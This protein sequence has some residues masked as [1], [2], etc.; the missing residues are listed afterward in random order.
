[1]GEQQRFAVALGGVGGCLVIAAVIVVTGPGAVTPPVPDVPATFADRLP[2]VPMPSW[3]DVTVAPRA[4]R[5]A[6]PVRVA[7]LES[8]EAVPVAQTTIGD[9]ALAPAPPDIDA[10]R[11]LPSSIGMRQAPMP[12]V[13][14]HAPRPTDTVFAAQEPAGERGPVTGAFI[15]AGTHVGGG[16]K[17]VGRTLKR[18]F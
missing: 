13:I 9:I 14:G 2:R 1:M 16:F 7:R 10:P 6:G 12:V 4:S 3:S 17:T 18:V 15:T 8:R 11:P 5:A